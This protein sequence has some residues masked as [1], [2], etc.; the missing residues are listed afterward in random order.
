ML[1]STYT[2]LLLAFSPLHKSPGANCQG[3][4][5]AI[6]D[7]SSQGPQLNGL[8]KLDSLESSAPFCSVASCKASE[9]VQE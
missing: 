2:W 4:A 6:L 5:A 8:A 9:A 3:C 7:L 1:V